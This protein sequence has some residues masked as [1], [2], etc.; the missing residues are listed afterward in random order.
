MEGVSAPKSE[1]TLSAEALA[2]FLTCLDPDADRAGEKYESLRLTLMKFFDW[3]GAHFPEELADETINRVIRKIDE[4]QTVRDIP[5]YCHGVARLVLLEKLK[6]PESRRADF[7]ELPPAALVAPEPEERDEIQDCFEQCLKELP[8]ESRQ[9]ILRYYGDEKRE[10]INR[11][12]AMAERLGIPLNA[13]R[14]RA[15]RIRNR[16]EEC[17]NGC[18]K[19]K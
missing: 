10:K 7:E 1:W 19:K 13:L 11:R 8:I 15:Q 3:R 12:Q 17:V 5:T 2:R 6:S 4:G 9:L 16:L 14:S 18:M